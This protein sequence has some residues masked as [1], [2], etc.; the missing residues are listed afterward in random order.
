ME[1]P[2]DKYLRLKPPDVPQ[3]E[4]EDIIADLEERKVDNSNHRTVQWKLRNVLKYG[5]PV[6]I[7]PLI[8]L[9]TFLAIQYQAII[10]SGVAIIITIVFLYLAS[11]E[12]G[13]GE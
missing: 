9:A 8:A 7:L 3:E 13:A 11:V 10:Y 2:D 12:V 1:P 4:W 6:A 5:A